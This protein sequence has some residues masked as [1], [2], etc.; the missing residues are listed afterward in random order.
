MLATLRRSWPVLIGILL[1]LFS[2][3]EAA[4]ILQESPDIL[5]IQSAVRTVEQTLPPAKNSVTWQEAPA[6]P[7][8]ASA[9]REHFVSLN[10]AAVLTS[11]APDSTISQ[12]KSQAGQVP[13]TIPPIGPPIPPGPPTRLVIPAIG[14]DAPVVPADSKTI[15]IAGKEYQQWK[16]PDR[17]AVGWHTTSAE[18]G[19]LGNTVLNGHNNIKGEVFKNLE[20]LSV[21]DQIQVYSYE[22]VFSYEIANLMILPEKYEQLD[23]RMNNAQWILPSQDERLTLVTCWP[24]KSNTHRLIIVARP[25]HRESIMRKLQ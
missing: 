6:S 24:Y 20:R 14:L 16:A 12:A 5:P 15:S 25:V 22:G 23:T 21:G 1:F 10:Q 17:F 3:Q 9:S 2:T 18:P 7:Q 11:G 13:P 4:A 8:Q 19:Q